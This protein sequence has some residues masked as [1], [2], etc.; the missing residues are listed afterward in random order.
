MNSSPRRRSFVL[1]VGPS[2]EETIIEG[3]SGSS[4]SV[5]SKIPLSLVTSGLSNAI[6]SS[7]TLVPYA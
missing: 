7:C 2:N 5:D 3:N 6:S 4:V 1:P